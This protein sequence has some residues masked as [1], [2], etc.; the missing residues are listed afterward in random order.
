[1][2]IAHLSRALAVALIVVG[3]G[4]PAVAKS[5]DAKTGD[6]KTGDAKKNV[7]T[8]T[9]ILFE[10]SHL[11]AVDKGSRLAYRF[12]RTVSD[13]KIL[14]K[15]FSDDITVDILAVDDKT[16]TRDLKIGVFSGDRGRD[17]QNITGMTGNPVLVVY[18]DRAV[19]QYS[20]LAGGARS[21]LKNQF[22]NGMRDFAKIEEVEVDYKSE[23]VAGYRVSVIPYN[24]DPNKLKMQGYEG[25]RFE[26]TLSDKVPGHF[27][28]FAAIYESGVKTA[29]RL[30]ERI[31]LTGVEKIQ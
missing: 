9:D 7:P 15:P 6:A 8:A 10:R 31:T 18:L 14:G 21:Y 28:E 24:E 11:A 29:P 25:S 26:I 22:R 4:V 12:Q 20:I 5:D 17:P 13:P 16:G 30:E 19:N 23:K 1:M 2:R 27:V 3:A